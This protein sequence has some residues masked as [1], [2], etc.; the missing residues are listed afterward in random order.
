MDEIMT[1]VNGEDRVVFGV[2]LDGRF[3]V[4]MPVLEKKYK[5]ETLRKRIAEG[6]SWWV[7]E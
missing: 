2:T 3:C 6:K 4:P 1:V 5:Y 7:V